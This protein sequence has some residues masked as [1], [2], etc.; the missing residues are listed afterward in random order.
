MASL[1]E[2]YA[3][4]E[5]EWKQTNSKVDKHKVFEK[6]AHHNPDTARL[7]IL[8]GILEE[9]IAQTKRLQPKHTEAE[10]DM[11]FAPVSQFFFQLFE[12]ESVKQL[13]KEYFG[14]RT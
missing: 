13:V 1:A 5:E 7:I 8:G 9:Y 10:N 6:I 4:F 2:H 3:R 11:E 14:D 12:Q